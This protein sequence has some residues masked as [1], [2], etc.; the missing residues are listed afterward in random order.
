MDS[1]TIVGLITGISG[2]VAACGTVITGF[3]FYGK[4]TQRVTSIEK[5]GGIM[6]ENGTQK[7]LPKVEF[8]RIQSNCQTGILAKIGVVEKETTVKF[9][10]QH[11]FIIEL[12][13]RQQLRLGQFQ[14]EMKSE[15]EKNSD[16]LEAFKEVHQKEMINLAEFMGEIRTIMKARRKGE[17]E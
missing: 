1:T 7:F 13:D 6:N 11:E 16:A 3:I 14:Q 8:T 12:Y 4:L 17:F 2:F 5:G 15:L 9:E 10:Q